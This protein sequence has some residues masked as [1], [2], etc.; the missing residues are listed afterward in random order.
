MTSRLLGEDLRGRNRRQVD[1]VLWS[2]MCGLDV[3]QGCGFL[4]L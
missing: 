1:Y 4:R 2:F 3:Q